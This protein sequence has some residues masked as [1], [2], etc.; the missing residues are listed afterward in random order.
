MPSIDL[1][2]VNRSANILLELAG[3]L[4][5][6]R[7]EPALTARAGRP[8]AHG[9]VEATMR[10]FAGFA[11]DQYQDAV[12]LLAALSMRLQETAAAYAATDEGVRQ[13]L[14]GFLAGTEYH[15]APGTE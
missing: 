12:A 10:E 6:G 14:D 5:A 3:T 11:A 13:T 8:Y 9:D 1:P 15:P 2:S 4:Q 7:P